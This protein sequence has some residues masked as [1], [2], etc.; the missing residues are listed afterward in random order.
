ME[1]AAEK[2][3]SSDFQTIWKSILKRGCTIVQE[4]NE[5]EFVFN[6]IQGCESYL[7]V[8]SA[9]GN[10]MYMLAQALK[11]NAKITYIDWDENHT[12]PYREEIILELTKQGF[13]ITPIHGNTHDSEVVMKANGRYEVVFIDAGHKF[14]DVIEDARNYGKMATKFIIFHDIMLPEVEEAFALYQKETGHRSYKIINS[15]SFGY[16]IMEI[17]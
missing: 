3:T 16:A 9:E 11:S 15:E 17:Q 10:S 8:G 12:R 13:F 6:L 5:L 7:E 1:N 4:Y 14:E 2:K